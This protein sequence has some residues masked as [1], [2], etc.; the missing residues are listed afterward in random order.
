MKKII[1]I[2]ALWVLWG[3]SL[4]TF[5]LL[6][7]VRKTVD[8]ARAN[9]WSGT[10]ENI[11]VFVFIA[12]L[13]LASFV[14]AYFSSKTI[15]SAKASNGKRTALI[16]VPILAAIIAVSLFL[17]PRL[18]NNDEETAIDAGFTIGPYPTKEKLKKLKSEGYT[19]IISLLHP[20]VVPFEPKLLSEEKEN[21]EDAGIRLINIP[22][23]PWISD[24]ELA[25]DSLRRLI[26]QLKGRT[27]VHCYL[28]KDRVNVAKQIILQ[29]S[30]KQIADEREQH[31]ARSLDSIPSFERGNIYKLS[32]NLY[33]T[34]MPTKE[35]YFGYI[36]AAGYKQV[37]SLNDF[38]DPESRLLL[39]E[40]KKWL[41]P[42]KISLKAFNI[43]SASDAKIKLIV[44]SVKLYKQPMVIHAFR[45]DQ[46]ESQLFMKLYKD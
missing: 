19:N 6:G 27:Y 8:Y 15:Q 18:I 17:N 4:G 22:L 9:N 43:N 7:P 2:T 31:N 13:I 45:S 38:N 5:V 40:E 36:I 1:T 30:K 44:D 34:P 42:Y 39:E 26:H 10:Q 11:T 41:A 20:A 12:I 16:A 23:L 21:T 29:E 3:F 28:G 24:N 46:P 25:I 35:E 32:Q 33:L 37:I 14:L